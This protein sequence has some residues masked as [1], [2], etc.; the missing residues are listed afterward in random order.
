MYESQRCG[1]SADHPVARATVIRPIRANRTYVRIM[2]GMPITNAEL[3]ALQRSTAM[4][5]PGQRV[6]VE[7]ERLQ[8]LCEELLE[9]RDLL[10]RLGTDL[11]RVA[12]R[13]RR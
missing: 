11:R 1:A 6:P 5:S 7:R 3:I 12:R 13:S 9:S 8:E 10:E 2:N 4:L